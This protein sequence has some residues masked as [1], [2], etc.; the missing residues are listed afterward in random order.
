[1]LST[2]NIIKNLRKPK[3]NIVVCENSNRYRVVC[4]EAKAKRTAY[5]FSVPIYNIDSGKLINCSFYQQENYINLLGSNASVA[6]TNKIQIKNAEGKC[7]IP[8]KYLPIYISKKRLQ[9]GTDYIFPTTNGIVY[10]AYCNDNKGFAF[11]M[12][13]DLPFSEICMNNRCFSI[14]SSQFRPFLTVSCI[15]TLNEQQKIIAPARLEY[16]SQNFVQGRYNL[17]IL[18]NGL[19][20][21]WVLFEINLYEPKLF[22]DTTVESFNPTINNTFG[23]TAF[24]G[25]TKEYG[26]QW[27]YSR[28]DLTNMVDVLDKKIYKAIW[29]IPVYGKE[30]IP[31]YA[32]KVHTRFCSF[33]STWENKVSIEKTSIIGSCRDGYQSFD[34]TSFITNPTTNRLITTDGILLKQNIRSQAAS[35]IATGDSHYRQQILEVNYT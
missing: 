5:Y 20:G 21:R 16:E 26:E 1:M 28:P 6:L 9:C 29:H 30:C 2:M 10:Q 25:K 12:K 23:G 34:I 8:L 7:C 13:V 32:Y 11:H 19:L 35:I 15:G 33:G 18:P 3:S 31:I 14:M 27:L 4:E 17:K 24:I 22:Q